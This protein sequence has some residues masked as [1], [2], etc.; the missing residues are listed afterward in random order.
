MTIADNIQ[1]LR[2]ELPKWV[3][4]ICVSKNQSEEAIMEAYNTGE[5]HF[6]ESHVQEL[7][8]KYEDLP[9]DIRWHMIGH[10]QTNKVKDIVPFVH[11]IQSV[12]SWKLLET[13]NTEAGK[14]G[15]KVAVLLE[16][17]VAQEQTKSGMTVDE[18]QDILP[19][20]GE[21]EY[22]E[23]VGLMTMATNTDDE[24]ELR[25][26]FHQ[27]ATLPS[28]LPSPLSQLHGILSM[29][30]S[31]DYPIAIEEGSNMIRVGSK[32]FGIRG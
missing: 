27:L 31:E 10:L 30:M 12:D 7:C 28:P 9:K 14:I 29:G 15:R 13:I 16:V 3:T 20:L 4:L 19:R 21:L 8:K 11:L 32:I 1:A 22:V 2:A 25:R 26:C 6:G 23:V 17:H 24:Q 5:R 18:L